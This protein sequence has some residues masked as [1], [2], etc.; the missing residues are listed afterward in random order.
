[1]LKT[2]IAFSTKDR[3]HLS[4]QSV[5]PLLQPDK[6]DLWWVDG[7][8]T[9]E[10]Q[11]LPEE[12]N[13]GMHVVRGVRGG[14][15]AAIVYSLTEML[16]AGYEIIGLCENDVLLHAD[17]FGP[18]TRLFERGAADGL[19]VGAVSPRCYEDR[20]LIQREGYAVCHNLGA[21][22]VLF[23][24]RAVELILQNYRTG[25]WP[26]SRAIFSQLCGLDIGRWGAFRTNAQHV[27]A[28][29]HFDVILAQH[30]LASLALT[31]SPVEM[32][33]QDPPL[34][35][36]GLTLV[37]E[38]VELLRNNEVFDHFAS[39]T[40]MVR[41]GLFNPDVV[42]PHLRASGSG[43]IYF[44]HQLPHAS[45]EPVYAGDWKLKWSAGFGPFAWEAVED[46]VAFPTLFGS[47]AFLVAGGKEG[48]KVIIRDTESGYE[49]A[50]AIPAGDQIALLQVPGD[51]RYRTISFR[52]EP[53]ALFYGVQT[54]EPQPTGKTKFDFSK[55]PRVE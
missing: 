6:F 10:G 44:A 45:G 43:H 2:A 51:M 49:I 11:E 48:A 31:P 47:V 54:N 33:G 1:M 4:R 30:G 14:A 53:G 20:V 25:W 5:A 36:Q 8:L 22:V 9:I 34:E 3:A 15:D 38:S 29:W 16:K 35:D 13:H 55:L 7:S 39:S 32:I 19:E 12:Y 52:A 28:D 42:Q 17:W 21:G 26:D 40:A 18:T 27:T 50:P 23:S 41:A 37:K 24:R 46:A